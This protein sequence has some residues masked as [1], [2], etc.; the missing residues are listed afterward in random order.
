MEIHTEERQLTEDEFLQYLGKLNTPML[1]PDEKCLYE[2]KL[3]LQE[4][5]EALMSIQNR[6]RLRR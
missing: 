4:C 6:K 2:G 5:W 3:T 1:T